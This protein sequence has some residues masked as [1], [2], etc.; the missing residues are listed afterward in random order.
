MVAASE[1]MVPRLLY[2]GHLVSIIGTLRHFHIASK[3]LS[4]PSPP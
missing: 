1:L 2:I 4:R 3:Q